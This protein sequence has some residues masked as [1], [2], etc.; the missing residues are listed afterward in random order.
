MEG[1][2]EGN[3]AQNACVGMYR[4]QRAERNAT[5]NAQNATCRNAHARNAV[6]NTKCSEDAKESDLCNATRARQGVLAARSSEQGAGD[7]QMTK[8]SSADEVQQG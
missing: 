4:T 1:A 8:C 2:G 3:R 6:E 7:V 5:W